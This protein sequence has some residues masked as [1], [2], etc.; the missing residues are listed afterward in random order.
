[1]RSYG[2][3]CSVI[4]SAYRCNEGTLT[5]DTWLAACLRVTGLQISRAEYAEANESF[6]RLLDMLEKYSAERLEGIDLGEIDWYHRLRNELY[7]QGN[8]LTVE[9]EKVVVYAGLAQVLFQRL[10]GFA[11]Q[12]EEPVGSGLVGNFIT[13]WSNLYQ[14]L[15][16]IAR[17][18]H[19]NENFRGTRTVMDVLRQDGLLD[20]TRAKEIQTLRM[21][22][23]EIVHGNTR[24]LTQDN[25]NRLKDLVYY[26]SQ[27]LKQ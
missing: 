4:C 5:A 10:F 21:L 26:Y 18:H 1:M 11:I 27:R 7:H 16:N 15:E 8:G 3:Q 14:I 19:P 12:V 23:N 2:R 24:N 17:D 9:R 22:R 13:T 20:G 6:P 25:I